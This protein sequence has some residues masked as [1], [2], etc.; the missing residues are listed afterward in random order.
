MRSGLLAL[1]SAAALLSAAGGA[2][3]AA[4]DEEPGAR[5]DA[6]LSV[7]ALRG[8]RI[9]ALVVD[10]DAGTTLFA[11]NPDRSLVPASNLKLLTAAAALN[12][13]G[14]AHRFVTQLLS[15]AAPDAEGAIG[16]LYVRGGGDPALTSEDFWRLAAD[17]GRLGVRRVRGDLVLDDSA[18][19]GER[20]HPSWGAVSARAYHAPIG[21]LTVNYGAFAV[22]LEPGLV[23]GEA[24]RA[25]VDPHVAFLRLTNGART[26]AADARRSLQ[27]DRRGS[28][29]FEQVLVSGIAPAGGE[30]KTYHRSVLDPARYA[31]AVLRMQL[32]AVGIEVA[33]ETRLGYVPES[34]VELLAF[35]GHPLAEVVR[36]F[37][38]YSN[39]A[40][41]EALV[42]SLGARASGGPGTWRG[43]LQAVR[44]ELDA[45][46]L[47]VEHL[48]LVDGSGLSYDNRATPRLLVEALRRGADSF[49]FGPEFLAA[50]PIA[51]A[52]GTLEERVE[53]ASG[54][55]RA[56]TGLLTRVTGLS[57]VAE[58]TDGSVA[59]FS[60]LVNGFRSS[61]EDAM[62]AVDGFL[63]ALVGD[64]ELLA[65][66]PPVSP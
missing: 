59:Y 56:K 46:G 5:L 17:L 57:G 37:L 27:V 45:L 25:D 11:R 18:F 29:R 55:V 15:D 10:G 49:S 3:A 14:P 47:P 61:A 41:G 7:R 26:G 66:S 8:A 62:D 42:K 4:P 31:G 50:L 38:K 12:A 53:E 16:N 33:G 24:V 21:A 30:A 44:D 1:I 52:D 58:R 43:G 23:A 54:R 20:W 35:S 64:Q 9:A 51:A 22:T 13:L 2:A 36:R 32:A 60:V 19:D 40:I 48:T 65:V 6:A 63:E 34:A 39:N 28:Q